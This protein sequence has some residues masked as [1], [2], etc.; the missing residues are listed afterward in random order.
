MCVLNFLGHRKLRAFVTHGG[1]LSM[2]E[3][4]FHGVPLVT[5]PVFCDHDVNAAKAVA[6][7]YALKLELETLTVDK[8]GKFGKEVSVVWENT[9]DVIVVCQHRFSEGHITGHS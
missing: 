6:D 9:N 4:V 7:G 3:S 5:M 1:L 8:L 2:F